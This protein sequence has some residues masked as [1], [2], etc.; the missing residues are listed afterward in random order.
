MVNGNWS[1]ILRSTLIALTPHANARAQWVPPL[2]TGEVLL[3]CSPEALRELT[4]SGESETDYEGVLVGIDPLDLP[5]RL[6]AFQKEIPK[7]GEMYRHLI[8][9]VR[10][11][12]YVVMNRLQKV[13]PDITFF[14]VWSDLRYEA[15]SEGEKIPILEAHDFGDT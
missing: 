1:Q 6:L 12:T 13:R 4:I 5:N 11:F 9:Q 14:A 3:L 10:R 2:K 15:V 7:T 8:I